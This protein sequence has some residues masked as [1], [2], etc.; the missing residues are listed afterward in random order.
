G[1]GGDAYSHVS[2]VSALAA[3]FSLGLGIGNVEDVALAGLLHDIGLA[4]IPMLVQEK[5]ASDRT[6]KEQLI[7]QQHPLLALQIIKKRQIDL[8]TMVLKII[9]QH[10]ERFDGRGYPAELRGEVIR[11][12]AQLLAI[13]DELE[14]MTQIKPGEPRVSVR[15]AVDSILTSSAYD[16]QLLQ[17]LS[18]LLA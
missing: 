13:A 14:Y 6:E 16:P 4:D 1:G 2:N 17:K 11:P 12:E 10:H 18:Q 7:Y 5:K 9:E 3:M 15:A 8:S